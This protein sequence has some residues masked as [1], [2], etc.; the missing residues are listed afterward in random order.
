M[1][2]SSA[3]AVTE[4]RLVDEMQ[5]LDALLLARSVLYSFFHRVFG[6]ELSA[7]LIEVA[8]SASM[9]DVVDEYAAESAEIVTWTQH[10]SEVLKNGE[11]TAEVIVD[12]AR[13][14]YMRAFVGPGKLLAIPWKSPYVTG[15]PSLFHECTLEVR[16]MYREQGLRP[17]RLQHV[18]DDHVALLCNF[19]EIMAQKTLRAFEQGAW[20]D[21]VSLM[22][23]QMQFVRDHLLN[24]LPQFADMLNQS[25]RASFYGPAAST[26]VTFTKIDVVFL[27]Q[28]QLWLQEWQEA[29]ALAEAANA[30][31]RTADLFP[32]TRAFLA[33]VETL[34]LKYMDDYELVPIN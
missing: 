26:L 3:V 31:Q 32:E 6:G 2:G 11:T 13:G 7:E 15:D 29:D 25:K 34:H 30:A 22:N 12:R 27:A 24:W 9:A 1:S 19:M 16:A 10:L 4:E 17:R 5:S 18:P 23:T 14:E 33:Q 28:I 8:T 20:D 21:L